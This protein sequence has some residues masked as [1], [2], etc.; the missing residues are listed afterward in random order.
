MAGHL[1]ELLAHACADVARSMARSQSTDAVLGDT[2]GHL[3]LLLGVGVTGV[4]LGERGAPLRVACV[5]DDVMRTLLEVEHEAGEGP[6]TDAFGRGAVAEVHTLID[7]GDRW[8]AWSREARA[9]G[10]GAWLAVPSRFEESTVV[11]TASS[12]RPRRWHEDEVSA[13][14]V[15]AD[16]AAS[17][18]ARETELGR[19]RRTA[20]QL[21]EALDHR[22]VIEQAKGIVAGELHCTLER[23]FALLREH[24]RSNSVSVRAVAEAVVHLGLRPPQTE[25]PNADRVPRPRLSPPSSGRPRPKGSAPGPAPS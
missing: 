6:S 16:L 24:A 3:T 13:V 18:V 15:L 23:A 14:Q 25:K 7:L 4:L 11:L 2:A 21:Q 20:D 19:A 9:R 22:L 1:K 8:P 17:C 5:T 12:T 10:I